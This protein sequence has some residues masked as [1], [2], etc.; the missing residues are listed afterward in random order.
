MA[1][2][3]IREEITVKYKIK[4]LAS[5]Q[6]ETGIYLVS[7]VRE[8]FGQSINDPWHDPSGRFALTDEEAVQVYGEEFF[9]SWLYQASE[10]LQKHIE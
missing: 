3:T 1:Q 9:V 4:A 2:H 8:E 6:F 7:L 5:F 10:W